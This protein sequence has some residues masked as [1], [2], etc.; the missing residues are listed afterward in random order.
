VWPNAVGLEDSRTNGASGRKVRA[1]SA[2]A[3]VIAASVRISMKTFMLTA[4]L[5]RKSS[6][7]L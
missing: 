3:R 4:P 2:Q 7:F 1:I 6:Q 5:T